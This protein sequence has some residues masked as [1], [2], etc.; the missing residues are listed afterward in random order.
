MPSGCCPAWAARARSSRGPPTPE[1]L[2]GFQLEGGE[3][4][5]LDLVDGKRTFFELCDQGPFS[6]GLN[7][8]VLYAFQCLGLVRKE[9]DST[10]VI[11]RSGALAG[12][13]ALK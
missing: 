13:V 8:R 10:S 3:E 7:A 5:L 6:A 12:S 1:N 4:Q 11:T 2:K 9:K